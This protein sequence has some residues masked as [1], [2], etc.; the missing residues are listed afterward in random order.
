MT[1]R[2]LVSGI[3]TWVCGGGR[4][5]IDFFGPGNANRVVGREDAD[6]GVVLE[7]QTA[8]TLRFLLDEILG[9]PPRPRA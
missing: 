4:V 5:V 7:P 6:A 8:R 3:S 9:K 1:D 2:R